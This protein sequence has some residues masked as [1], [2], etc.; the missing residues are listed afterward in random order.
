MSGIDKISFNPW[1][2]AAGRRHRRRRRT[3]LASLAG[4]VTAAVAGVL[5][6][7]LSEPA[8]SPMCAPGV[9]RHQGQCVGVTDSFA[10]DRRFTA[11]MREL[12]EENA[13]AVE[14]GP[15][16][17]VTV[18]FLGPLTSADDRA[19]IQLEG[20]VVG[21]RRANRDEL[22]GDSP[23]IR[24]VLGNTGDRR[25]GDREWGYVTDRLTGMV[26]GADHLTAVIGVGLS[27]TETV[28]AAGRLRRLSLPMIG[29]ALTADRM[30]KKLV[31]GL[32]KVNPR[33][34]E[35]IQLLA[36]HLRTRHDLRR[37]IIVS[38]S[39][40]G[41]LYAEALVEAF[42]KHLAPQWKAGGSHNYPF[43]LDPG[44]DFR[45]IV[46]NLCSADP[47]ETIL[48][49]GR[50]ADLPKFIGYLGTRACHPERLTVIT[51]SDAVYLTLNTTENRKAWTYLTDTHNPISLV[52]APLAEPSVLLDPDR[53]PHAKQYEAFQEAYQAQGFNLAHLDIGWGIMAHD[54]LLTAA[55]AIRHA[56]VPQYGLPEPAK[57]RD[58]LYLITTPA[59]SVPGASGPI[60]LDP[61][62]G[63]RVGLRLPILQFTPNH[64]PKV[65]GMYG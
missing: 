6:G 54:A 37:A 4:T 26:G 41:D 23:R 13:Y 15:G 28:A 34:G 3:L 58:A 9:L 7:V 30:D 49:A 29:N 48:Y 52:Y 14:G 1:D 12:R 61:D 39:E 5:T 10:F 47:A 44:N 16:T 17:Y 33:V 46:S 63:N 2:T 32:A 18:A 31:L 51:G 53:N 60:V 8:V 64:P 19:V 38:Y 35:E 62:T 55:S 20:A 22:V 42:K 65:L 40:E 45:L 56:T 11:I 25:P 24:L 27:R 57:V 59:T 36:Q 43:G 21:L 50:A